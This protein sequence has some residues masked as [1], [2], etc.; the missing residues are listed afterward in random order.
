MAHA[1]QLIQRIAAVN[2]VPTSGRVRA[3]AMRCQVGRECGI[4]EPLMASRKAGRAAS[5]MTSV[6]S[7]ARPAAARR[8]GV[9]SLVAGARRMR[10]RVR[11]RAGLAGARIARTDSCA[12]ATRIR[13]WREDQGRRGSVRRGRVPVGPAHPGC[14][15]AGGLGGVGRRWRACRAAPRG[16]IAR[17]RVRLRAVSEAVRLQPHATLTTVRALMP[18]SYRAAGAGSARAPFRLGVMAEVTMPARNEIIGTP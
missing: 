1:I 13:S 18:T 12:R 16:R 8:A 6:I 7:G 14:P 3:A 15:A 5:N 9:S 11:G 17:N 4:G 2:S 10:G